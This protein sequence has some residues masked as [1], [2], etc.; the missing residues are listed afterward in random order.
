MC[1]GAIVHTRI[2]RV[3]FGCADPQSGAAGGNTIMKGGK[4][5][6]STVAALPIP[7]LGGALSKAQPLLFS[8]IRN[9]IDHRGGRPGQS[10]KK[11]EAQGALD[12][13]TGD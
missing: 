3:I 13:Q 6:A 9:Q 8:A 11:D 1:A 5:F 12:K 7:Y 4:Q 10:Q 2:R